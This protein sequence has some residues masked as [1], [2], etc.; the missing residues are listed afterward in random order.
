MITG[1]F[2]ITTPVTVSTKTVVQANE[3]FSGLY[4]DAALIAGVIGNGIAAILGLGDHLVDG[5]AVSG[6]IRFNFD[7][8]TAIISV[9]GAPAISFNSLP[10]GFTVSSA[11]LSLGTEGSS[12]GGNEYL[13]LDSLTEGNPIPFGTPAM[14]SLAYDFSQIPQPT[15][16]DIINNGFGIRA[17][18]N[19]IHQFCY[20]YSFSITGTYFIQSW[21]WDMPVTTAIKA[22][23]KFEID[24]VPDLIDPTVIP[25]VTLKDIA[26][27]VLAYTD[28]D[29]NEVVV[30]VLAQDFLVWNY[31]QIIFYFP[32]FRQIID[33]TIRI[34][35]VGNGTQFS[36]TVLLGTLSVIFADV[37]GIYTL[38]PNKR[39]DTVYDPDNR[40]QTIEV[41][42]PDPFLETAYIP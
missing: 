25:D 41:H 10:S 37:S 19:D 28:I 6:I 24:A 31:R 30:E 21:S 23:D 17:A 12:S 42:I 5:T 22:G 16:L 18:F 7:Q 35:A 3:E 9:D 4:T 39:T 33:S 36:G 34:Y 29:G 1:T 26:A 14:H 38:V 11:I 20:G 2:R 8:N 40:G 15:M 13:Q 32:R 27:I